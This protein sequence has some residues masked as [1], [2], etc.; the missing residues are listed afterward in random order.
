[1]KNFYVTYIFETKEERDGFLAEVRRYAEISR[2]EPGCIRYD[3]FY[4]VDWDNRL[5]LWEQWETAQD[6]KEHCRKAH[7]AHIG[8]LKEK[9]KAK[10]EIITEDNN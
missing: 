8:K 5:F 7:F 2:R 3:Y 10:T 6:Q 4:P 1:M 9:Y